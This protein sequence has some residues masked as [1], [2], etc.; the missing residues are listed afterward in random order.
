MTALTGSK[1]E[2]VTT[3]ALG[4]EKLEA[5]LKSQFD[6]GNM[7]VCTASPVFDERS[8]SDIVSKDGVQQTHAYS[9]HACKTEPDGTV[10]F[11]LRNPWGRAG[12]ASP[13]KPFED[14]TEGY[15]WMDTAEMAAHFWA[16][17]ACEVPE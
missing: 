12:L 4:P 3:A 2:M 10:K 14:E 9:M 15:F 17:G 7:A 13:D 5:W 16:F 11:K 8:S 6:K 1:P